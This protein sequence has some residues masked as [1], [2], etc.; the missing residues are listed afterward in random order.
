MILEDEEL[1]EIYRL[2]S[3]EHLQNLEAG[4]LNLEQ[5]PTQLE[6]ITDLMREAHSLKGDSRVVG[7]STMEAVTHAL[8]DV[9]GKIQNR[10]LTLT[11]QLCD[12]L[13]T[14]LDGMEGLV[15]EA[16]TG[17]PSSVSSESLV[18]FLTAE[19]ESESVLTLKDKPSHQD[20]HD[21]AHIVSIESNIP[22]PQV[23]FSVIEDE[24][25]K[26]IYRLSSQEHLQ[27]LEAGILHLEQNPTQLEIITDLMREAHSLKGDS[28]VVGVSTMEA[29]THALEDVL[30]KIQTRELTLTSQLCDRLYTVLDG[31]EGLVK[32]A[33][34]GEPSSVS[35][36]SL[37]EFLTAK[38][39][40]VSESVSVVS[41]ESNI[42]TSQVQFSVIED[43]ELKDIYRLSSQEHLQ[44]LEAGILNLEQDPTQLGIITDLMREAHS[45]KG[46]SRVVGVSTMEAVT[47]ALEDVLGKIQNR[48]LTLTSQLSDRLYNTLDGMQKLVTEALTGEPS[49]INPE[50]LVE[51]LTAKPE[52]VSES[53]SVVSI[54][55]NIPTSQLQF[56]VIEDEE[57]K[58]IY[59]LSSQEHLQNLEAGILNLEQNPTQLEIITD[60]MR[61]AHSL[62]GDSRVVGVTTMEAVTH[63][64][65]DVLG[66]IQNRS[67]TL[68]SQLCDRL[69]NTLDGMQKLVTEA[70]TGEPS[71]VDLDRLI[72]AIEQPSSQQLESVALP[73]TANT[74]ESRSA[75]SLTHQPRS[76][77]VGESTAISSTKG[78]SERSLVETTDEI[79][80]YP[81]KIEQPYRIDTV[82]VPTKALDKLV[83]QVGEL[84]VSKTRTSH[85][86]SEIQGICNLWKELKA[87]GFQKSNSNAYS[88]EE[89]I[90]VRLEQKLKNLETLAGENSA[91]LEFVAVELE[92]KIANLRQLPLSQVFQLFPRLVRDLAK[93]QNKQVQLVIQGG[94]TQVDKKILEEIKD[95]LMHLIRNAIDHGIEIPTERIT[96]GKPAQAT[97]RLTGYQAGNKIIIEL[98]DDGRGLNVEKIKNTAIK[99]GLHHPEELANMSLKQIHS[100]IFHPGFSTSNFVTEVSG[101]GVGMDVVKNN[102]EKLKGIIEIDSVRDRGSTF[103]LRLP[104]TLAKSDVLLVDIHDIVH[105]IPIDFVE[106][107]LQIDPQQ[108]FPLEG[109]DTIRIDGKAVSVANLADLLKITNSPAYATAAN[110]KRL[111]STLKSCVLMKVGEER[112]GLIVDRLLDITD[113]AF[114][115]QG[116]ILRRVRNVAGAT[117][118][119]TGKVCMILD[120]RDLLQSLKGNN[121]SLLAGASSN[122]KI[123]PQSDSTG[124]SDAANLSG[125]GKYK[126]LLAE[127]SVL[128]RTQEK[129]LLEAAGYEVITAVDGLDG[130]NKLQDNY[131]D[132]VISDVE[133][134]NLDGFSFTERIRQ[135]DEYSELPIV[136]VTSLATDEDK[137]KGAEAGANAYIVKGQFSQNVLLDTLAR[138]I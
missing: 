20:S 61:D 119:G 19:E 77:L 111:A 89:P 5:N 94:D 70:L 47:H 51:F 42:P 25:L 129:R 45:L 105:A 2:S 123:L 137:R 69:Y 40:S 35:S 109:R 106:A 120:A 53:V 81:T 37:V 27:N 112:F 7:V 29:V 115:P 68:T 97:V 107:N 31:M 11:S 13:Y 59:R 113:V 75:A 87:T 132:A 90:E 128:V 21:I 23:Q 92:E 79:T 126:I 127:D 56:S 78:S 130:Y 34:T 133:M 82:R 63:A 76:E 60:L 6:I 8:E 88:Q 22:T 3:Q 38:S 62:K 16:L 55:S 117:I 135:N 15:T 14:V 100:L 134:P 12:R 67:L 66:K 9:L 136:L 86:V 80:V 116:N 122:S 43:E 1:K 4:I 36:E 84:I 91:K 50:S 28:R 41:I 73:I 24:E 33:L 99:K 46:D 49:G 118:L 64:L 65:E 124:I 121:S 125:A 32:E 102:I 26:D 54:E 30:G 83:T 101:R 138:L 93:E 108:I 39:E 52:S 74:D 104:T 10:S 98:E 85:T 114:K 103:H 58:D 48:S 95:P 72:K 110:P 96:A 57:L 17:E 71:N 131:F 18:E 44:N